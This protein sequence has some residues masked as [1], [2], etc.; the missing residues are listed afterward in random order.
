MEDAELPQDLTEWQASAFFQARELDEETD[1]DRLVESGLGGTCGVVVSKGRLGGKRCPNVAGQGTSHVGWGHCVIHGGAKRSGRALGAWMA[2]HAFARELDINPWDALLMAVRIAAGKV[3]Y[4]ETVLGQASSD[5]ELEGRAVRYEGD[6]D[7]PALLVHPDTGEPLGVGAYRDRSWWVAKGEYWHAQLART[8]KMAVDAGVA[9][10][11]V[12]AIEAQAQAI[13]TVLN[14]MLES[15][16]EDGLDDSMISRLRA[17]ARKELLRLEADERKS[18]G[19][20]EGQEGW[21]DR[22]VVDSSL[23]EGWVVKEPEAGP[24]S[25]PPDQDKIDL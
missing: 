1:P 23:V 4:I 24:G 11:Q 15:A 5:L 14:G 6:A 19:A 8:A 25:S 13:A 17:Y 10:Y 12:K 9:V 18:L 20:S 3:A 22:P 7:S 21:Q 2:A 16:A